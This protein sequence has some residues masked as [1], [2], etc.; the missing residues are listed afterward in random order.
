MHIPM[1]EKIIAISTGFKHAFCLAQQTYNMYAYGDKTMSS[2]ILQTPTLIH[3]FACPVQFSVG[4]YHAFAAHDNKLYAFGSN[5]CCK[6][7]LI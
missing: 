1:P 3:C 5:V 7:F 4:R 6:W 2:Y